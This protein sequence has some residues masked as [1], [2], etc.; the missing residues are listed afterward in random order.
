VSSDYVHHNAINVQ[1]FSLATR[2]EIILAA[3]MLVNNMRD[4]TTDTQAKKTNLAVMLGD[5]RSRW[6]YI[7][8]L[9][10]VYVFHSVA[11][12]VSPDGNQL[13]AL[14]LPLIIYSLFVFG[15]IRKIRTFQGREL[16]DLIA[17]T[18]ILGVVYSLSTSV[19][20][21]LYPL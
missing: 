5:A 12:A 9:M 19:L 17:D 15:V 8:L 2:L 14:V 10:G 7:A 13:Y 1:L 4:I 11:F 18:A 20:I 16:N 21:Q 3:I 6:L